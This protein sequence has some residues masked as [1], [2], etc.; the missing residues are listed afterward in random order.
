MFSSAGYSVTPSNES[1]SPTSGAA[2]GTTA[3]VRTLAL[4]PERWQ[5]AL[6]VGIKRLI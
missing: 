4:P 5:C 3:S 1:I 6:R 2:T